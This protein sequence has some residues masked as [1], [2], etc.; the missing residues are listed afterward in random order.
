MIEEVRRVV[1]GERTDRE[2]AFSHIEVVEPMKL[3]ES[4]VW[5]VWGW[6]QT[7]TL[8]HDSAAPYVPR[9]WAPPAGGLRI[10]ATRFSPQEAPQTDQDRTTEAA[11][12]ALAE[13]EPCGRYDD[14]DRP[15]MHRTDSVDIGVVVSGEVTVEAGDGEKVVLQPGDVYVQNGAIHNWH[16]DSHSR[17]HVV[18]ISLG[19]AR[20]S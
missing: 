12:R 10:S 6:D 16:P 3:G 19:V 14:P 13:A 4:R 17:A 18:F 5:H 15:G 11:L 20:A 2:S 9:S 7:P 8:P 1:M